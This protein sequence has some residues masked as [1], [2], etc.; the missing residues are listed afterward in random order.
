MLSINP[1]KTLHQLIEKL[2]DKISSYTNCIKIG[3]I[4]DFNTSNQT[5][6]VTIQ[7]KISRV[8]QYGNRVLFD[9]PVL[10]EVPVVVLGGGNSHI[11]FPIS[12]GDQCLV[13]FNDYELDQWWVSNES[14]PSEFRREHDISDGI[15]L[16]GIHSLVDLIQGYSS[17]VELKYSDSSKITLG[18]TLEID[19][20]TINLNGNVTA[21]DLHSNTGA[22][23]TFTNVNGQTL[24]IVDGIITQIS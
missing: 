11:T 22:T 7:H 16:V 19:N 18:D 14:R 21:S 9:Y 15:A 20:G 23:G 5:V 2:S 24:T 4:E 10:K 1:K 13:L 6:T 3:Q 12:K 17:F 8:D